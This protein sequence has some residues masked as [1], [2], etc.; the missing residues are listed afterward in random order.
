[1]TANER[2]RKK[3][4]KG[5]TPT[6]RVH[7]A[8]SCARSRLNRELLRV[9]HPRGLVPALPREPIL[10]GSFSGARPRE[11]IQITPELAYV[12]SPRALAFGMWVHRHEL[13]L[14]SSRS[15]FEP[16]LMG[17]VRERPARPRGLLL[18]MSSSS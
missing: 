1:M 8:V 10:V 5:K 14:V 9:S 3:Q 6:P 16:L 11:L 2:K 18:L 12:H 17:S 13:P 4:K 15:S 7:A